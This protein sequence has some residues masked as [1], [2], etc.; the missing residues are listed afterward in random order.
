MDV[1]VG[2][3][4]VF[5]LSDDDRVLLGELKAEL[6]RRNKAGGPHGDYSSYYEATIVGILR[7]GLRLV[8]TEIGMDKARSDVI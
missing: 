6:V 7:R 5:P 8:A 3:Q 2:R 4:A 1:Q